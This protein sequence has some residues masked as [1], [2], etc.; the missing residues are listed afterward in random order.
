MDDSVSIRNHSLK[1][2]E[3]KEEEGFINRFKYEWVCEHV[4]VWDAC[5]TIKCPTTM[6]L[7]TKKCIHALCHF[8]YFSKHITSQI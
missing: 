8:P 3:N 1:K 4:I 2:V 5:Y 6:R 7:A